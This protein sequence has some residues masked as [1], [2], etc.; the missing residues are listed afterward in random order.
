MTFKIALTNKMEYPLIFGLYLVIV[1]P[2][3]HDIIQI[4]IKSK[5]SIFVAI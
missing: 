4:Y 1:Y 3:T 2:K 5:T